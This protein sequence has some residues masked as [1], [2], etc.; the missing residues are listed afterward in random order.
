M[1]ATYKVLQD[2]IS[3][4]SMDSPITIWFF[5]DVHRDTKN[6]D[7]ERWKYFLKKAE[8]TMDENT[9]FIGMG[10]YHDFASTREKKYLESG[11]HETTSTLLDEVAEKHNRDLANE[12]SFMRGH[13][14][15]LIE[16]N[17]SW[18]FQ[19]G[20]TSTEDLA[21]RLGTKD[22]GWLCHYTLL[23]HN[24]GS[25]VLNQA[26]HMIL[27]HGKAGGKTAGITVNQVADLKPLFP[28]ADIYCMGHDHQRIA[29]PSSCLVP[30]K[31]KGG[32]K[33]KQK[34]QLLCRSGSFVKAYQDNS[35]SYEI[36][37]LY[38]PSDL[39]ALKI[40][41]GFHR[42]WNKGD[43]RMITDIEAII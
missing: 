23:C 19:T 26:I 32:Y 40:T 12:L 30:V 11:L 41:I 21:E 14:L 9:Y 27:C 10:D 34:R 20:K 18:R 33:I 39:G 36:F 31:C 29:H 24:K 43:E 2:E 5:G 25:H 28:I 17:H 37:R 15:G 6:C 4:T 35:N 1:K 7:E 3:I 42:D 22:L 38:K 8:S 13:L 16:G